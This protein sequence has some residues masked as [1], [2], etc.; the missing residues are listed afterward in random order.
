VLPQNGDGKRVTSD[1][2]TVAQLAYLDW[3]DRLVAHFFRPEMAGRPVYLDVTRELITDLGDDTN[4]GIAEFV[5]AVVEGPPWVDEN[6]GLCQKALQALDGWR[7][8]G[9]AYPPYLAYL[10]LFIA[11]VGVEGDFAPHAYYPRL[12]SLLGW[13]LDGGAPASFH[14]MS[15]LWD[16]LDLWS[17][18]DKAGQLGVFT[19]RFAGEWIHVGLPKA[20]ALL[21]DPEREALL[22]VF[23]DAG[24]DPAGEPSD[25][26]LARIIVDA[27]GG[28]FRHQ[29]L[30]LLEQTGEERELFGALLEAVRDEL[31]EWDGSR[32][33]AVAAGSPR[34]T[35]AGLRLSLRVDRVAR[36]ANFSMRCVVRRPFPEEGLVFTLPDGR[37]LECKEEVP[38][39][40]SPLA[41]AGSTEWFDSAQLDWRPGIELTDVGAGWRARLRGGDVRILVEGAGEGLPGYVE[42]DQLP[43]SRP[44]LVAARE[45]AGPHLA[46]WFEQDSQSVEELHYSGVPSG[47]SLYRSAG[48]TSDEVIRGRYPS[49]SFSRQVRILLRRGVRTGR[50]NS[51][52]SFA[53]PDVVVTGADSADEL[54]CNGGLLMDGD[55]PREYALPDDLRVDEPTVLEVKRNEDVL[56]RLTI[57][58]DRAPDWRSASVAPALDQFGFCTG[59]HAVEPTADADPIHAGSAYTLHI[60]APQDGR[61]VFLIGRSPGQISVHPNDVEWAPVWA[62]A[63]SRRGEAVYCGANLECDHPAG[64]AVGDRDSRR[65]WRE[66]LWQRRKQITPPRHRVLRALWLE[67]VEAARNA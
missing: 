55:V 47:W 9:C 53:P 2:Q 12:R 17:N 64:E 50:G 44:Y 63:L 1:A 41:V 38:S 28:R 42:V 46:E 18:R 48:A 24:L 37:S 25:Y 65:E 20:Q 13:E 54:Y 49:L 66:V 27:G 6:L 56:R 67:Y 43:R 60:A 3:N 32:P 59:V 35:I 8:R 10:G 52:F 11:A 39:W 23:A 33:G 62:V 31:S 15:A 51:F 14:R 40:S 21:T 16:D 58:F 61:R 22:D 7:S 36:R 57:Y 26:E 30:D 45:N 19:V 29:T 5:A 4:A 34:G